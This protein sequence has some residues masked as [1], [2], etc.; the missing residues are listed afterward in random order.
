MEI[1]LSKHDPMTSGKEDIFFSLAIRNVV[2]RLVSTPLYGLV[3]R[4]CMGEYE[5]VCTTVSVSLTIYICAFIS[6]NLS[7][8]SP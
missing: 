1:N 2:D 3:S 8:P 6:A 4:N 7:I 5:C